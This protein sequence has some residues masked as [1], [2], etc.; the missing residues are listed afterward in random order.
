M[1]SGP[2]NA[3][4]AYYH[5]KV[6]PGRVNLGAELTVFPKNLESTVAFGAEFNL[7]QSKLTTSVD[8]TGKVCSVLEA[9]V[10]TG[11]KL[12]LTAEVNLNAKDPMAGPSAKPVDQY[13]FGYGLAL[14]GQ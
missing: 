8:G 4:I 6:S 2:G 9:T 7:K 1:P 10:G 14:G 13:R 11:A 5:R 3:V 12:T